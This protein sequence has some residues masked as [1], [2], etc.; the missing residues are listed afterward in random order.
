VFS[1]RVGSS[2]SGTTHIN[3]GS[4]ASLGGSMSSNYSI[5]ELQQ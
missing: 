5:M 4:S 1:L 3:Q 2:G